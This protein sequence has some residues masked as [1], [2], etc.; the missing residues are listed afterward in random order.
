MAIF[1]NR[2]R[3][4]APAICVAAALQFVDTTPAETQTADAVLL[5]PERVW[6]GE[7]NE[8]HEG[9]GVLV[10]DGRIV[11]AGPLARL[12]RAGAR[13][14]ELPGS[15]LVPGLIEGHTHLFLHPYDET[16]WNDQVLVESEAERTLRAGR[17]ASATLRAGFT[18]AR[19]LGTEGAGY[20]DAGLKAA[21]EK[22]VVEGP[23]LVIASR[24]IV[25]TGSY[26]PRGFAPSFRPP[27]GAEAAD[28]ADLERV[29]RDQ[30]GHG[31]DV[32]KVYADYRWGP[33]GEARPT[34][35][36]SELERIV[37]VAGS[38]GRDVVAHASSDEAIRRATLAGVRTIEHGQEA[39]D[40]TL[41]IMAERGVA[42]CP[43]LAAY[44]A[45]TIY[46]GW[47]PGDP[48][49]EAFAS[50]RGLIGRAL[51]A[52]VPICVGSDAGVFDHGDNARELELLV[53][54]GLTPLQALRAATSGNAEALR[55][56]DRGRIQP[57]LLA[58]LVAFGGDPTRDIGA[59]RDVRM[60]M[61]GGRVVLPGSTA[62]GP[63]RA[64][65][66]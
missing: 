44:E 29:V 1:A 59:L 43:T 7:G 64:G 40:E 4:L 45:I 55:L 62:G 52:G 25:A 39:S 61:L 56:P 11:Q 37:E 21:I 33:A 20:A 49:P 36:A 34:F 63:A 26:G 32:I 8:V 58:D 30:I 22:G 13:V 51:A 5:A 50:R 12:D 28:G 2:R 9:W 3:S 6:D 47:T 17:H 48:E 60:V 53:E 42:L 66:L 10:R 23:R 24:A 16:D 27:L 46:A 35:T 57:G 65:G 15:T 31:A 54:A 38:S 18:T 19:D 14:I 41:A